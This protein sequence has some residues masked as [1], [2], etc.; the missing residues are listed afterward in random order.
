MIRTILV[1]DERLAREELK[2]LLKEHKEI[3]IIDEAGNADEALDK[4]EQQ[5]PDLVFL[6]IQMPGRDGF[7]MLEELIDVPYVIFATAFDEHALKAFDVNALDYLVKPIDAD[8]LAGSVQKAINSISHL[9]ELKE[10]NS[11]EY[12]SVGD[13]VFVKDGGKCWFVSLN[14]VRLFE[15]M[16]NYVKVHFDKN[17]PLIHKSLNSLGDKLDP[18]HFFRA[19]RQQI[20]NLNWIDQIQPWFSGGLLLELKNGEKVELSRRQSIKFR[21][22]KSF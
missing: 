18:K 12:L 10:S 3:D 7:E 9:R 5:K 1:D 4:I 20:V 15:S 19:N 11:F 22:M 13:R 16:G 2:D 17:Q 6:D 14:E 21:D 8:R